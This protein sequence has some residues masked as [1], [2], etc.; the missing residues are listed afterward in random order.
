LFA[1]VATVDEPLSEYRVHGANEYA[2]LRSEEKLSRDLLLFEHRCEFLACWCDRLGR[3]A[4][5]STW[6]EKSWFHRVQRSLEEVAS[7]VAPGEKLVLV[8]E[9]EWGVES[10]RGRRCLPFPERGGTYWGMPEDGPSALEELARQLRSYAPTHVVFAWP[11]FWWLD[12]YAELREYLATRSRLVEANDRVR[13]F[14][15]TPAGAD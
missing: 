9:D 2:A 3:P 12:Y 11:A 6:L 15:F 5:T 14:A 1:P 13:I 8:D 7:A 10:I 4:D